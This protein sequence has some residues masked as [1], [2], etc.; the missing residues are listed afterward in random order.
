MTVGNMH[1]TFGEV[2]EFCKRTDRQTNKR[3]DILIT[4]LGTLPWGGGGEVT[5]WKVMMVTDRPSVQ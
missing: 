3:T 4:I 5:M 1:K 2:F